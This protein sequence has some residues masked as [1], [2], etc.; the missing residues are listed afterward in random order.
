MEGPTDKEILDTWFPAVLNNPRVVIIRGGGGYN[1]R[2]AGLFASWL[3][4]AD[5]LG[6]RRVLYV[7]DRDELSAEFLAKLEASENVYVLPCRELEN[8]MLDDEAIAAVINAERERLGKEAVTVE[9]VSTST[10]EFA[11]EL[12]QVV[13]LKQT[14]ADLAEPIRLVDHK[15]RGNL[16]K[17]SADKSALTAEVLA[18]VPTAEAIEEKISSTWEQHDGDT[19]SS[20]DADW[21]N[22][23]PG[24]EVL[25]GLWQ[26]YL[27]RKYKKSKDGLALAEAM[28]QPPQVL[29]DLLDKFMQENP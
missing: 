11:D 18:R 6:Q 5:G 14:M 17:Q 15:M 8:L 12:Q 16:A 23:A 22:L 26:K 19:S 1:A 29:R 20:W 2:H 28:E 10:R 25:E 21:K 27:G 9:D 4:E 24:E 3:D 13:V 7:R